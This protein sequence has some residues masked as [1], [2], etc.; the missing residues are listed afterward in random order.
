MQVLWYHIEHSSHMPAARD[1]PTCNS[2]QPQGYTD[3]LHMAGPWFV[4]M[5]PHAKST[6]S[7]VVA[8]CLTVNYDFLGLNMP[9]YVPGLPVLLHSVDRECLWLIHVIA[10]DNGATRGTEWS[11]FGAVNS[12]RESI[13]NATAKQRV[14]VHRH[15]GWNVR[16]GLCDIYMRY[17]YI[18]VVY[19][20]CLFCCL[21]II[22]TWWYMWCIVWQVAIKKKYRHVW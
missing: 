8:G 19:S 21:F 14:L 12:L 16:H 11:L 18:W 9:R 13:N 4:S 3:W 7:K 17:V 15:Q 1:H 22:V 5:S 10:L 20:F 2:Y 6:N